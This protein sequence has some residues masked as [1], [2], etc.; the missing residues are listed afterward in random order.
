M[1]PIRQGPLLLELRRLVFSPKNV[2]TGR[3]SSLFSTASLCQARGNPSL[4]ASVT[5]TCLSVA[6]S[7]QAADL[8]AV[9]TALSTGALC[10]HNFTQQG[11]AS[12]KAS[13]EYYHVPRVQRSATAVEWRPDQNHQVAVGLTAGGG[14]SEL[15][16]QTQQGL[17][18]AVAAGSMTGGARG[19][20][21]PGDRDYCCFLWDIEH[22]SSARRTKAAPVH[23]LAHQ[24]G[25]ASLAW[26][27]EGGHI[28]A[29]GSQQRN[30]QVHDMRVQGT[31]PPLSVYAHNFG[32]HG[33]RTDPTRPWQ[34]ATF[35]KAMGETIKLWDIRKL[36]TTAAT[37]VKLQSPTT[38][39]PV[40]EVV[41]WSPSGALTV[42]AG[43]GYMYLYD[44]SGNRPLCTNTLHTG[45][46]IEDVAHFPGVGVDLQDDA[47][48]KP[49]EQLLAKRIV[50]AR[51]DQSLE[52]IPVHRAA[53]LTVSHR[54]GQV[55]HASGRAL[56]V[57]QFADDY[58]MGGEEDIS[59]II[60]RRTGKSK[61]SA[62]Y[63]MDVDRNIDLLRYEI[64]NAKVAEGKGVELL[65]LWKWIR[66]V[67]RS[68][69]EMSPDCHEA[70]AFKSLITAGAIQLLGSRKDE[71]EAK[72]YSESVLCD[73]YE[74]P[75]R[76]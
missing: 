40:V 1:T 73:V 64:E 59:T 60:M 37:E 20:A 6:P 51:R 53:P 74:S 31:T 34:F 66:R 11:D 44:T 47:A 19:A 57:H 45:G 4:G 10:I 46:Q 70:P 32:V 14:P 71:S 50:V 48:V 9:A 62:R 16:Q 43:D 58:I 3:S 49:F 13:T 15:R 72:T 17:R 2:E 29:L 41:K 54:P 63:S 52:D 65:R 39:P 61:D 42:L 30:V 5:S 7:T 76:Q 36:E 75:A 67:E 68:T 27:S 8:P 22:Q 25:I 69:N 28:L 18:L 38:S 33:V 23:R 26:V 35:S 12:W 56:M 21:H 55:I 24:I